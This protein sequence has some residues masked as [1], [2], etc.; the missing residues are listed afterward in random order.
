MSIQPVINWKE[1]APDEILPGMA[2]ITEQ[3]LELV[4]SSASFVYGSIIRH[5]QLIHPYELEWAEA[6]ANKRELG[7]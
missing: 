6:M 1:G 4:G 3:G 5:A 7:R 2:L